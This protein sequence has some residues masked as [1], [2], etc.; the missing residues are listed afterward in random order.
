LVRALHTESARRLDGGG[1]LA[2]PQSQVHVDQPV[3]VAQ[4]RHR[5]ADSAS[6]DAEATSFRVTPAR[7][8]RTSSTRH[9]AGWVTRRP[10]RR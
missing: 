9:L 3:F 2:G 5:L 1:A 6:I 7:L 4:L 8:A 10:S